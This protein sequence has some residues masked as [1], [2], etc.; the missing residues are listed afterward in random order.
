MRAKSATTVALPSLLSLPLVC[1]R[2]QRRH[3]AGICGVWLR[4]R[5][6]HLRVLAVPPHPFPP[7]CLPLPGPHGLNYRSM[8]VSHRSVVASKGGDSASATTK[9]RRPT[10]RRGEPERVGK[11]GEGRLVRMT[12]PFVVIR[13]P[14]PIPLSLLFPSIATS[15]PSPFLPPLS[16]YF[17]AAPLSPFL[18]P[19]SDFAAGMT[20]VL[21]ASGAWLPER[22][23]PYN[24]T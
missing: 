5:R 2:V 17:L 18:P 7:S 23:Q 10:E 8:R 4:R 11:K 20:G 22:L 15:P 21:L 12:T 19:L 6:R 9:K 3:G 13:S 24:P 16:D 1:R 14:L